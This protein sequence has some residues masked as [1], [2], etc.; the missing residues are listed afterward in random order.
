MQLG[1]TGVADIARTIASECQR[2]RKQ[3]GP[4]ARVALHSFSNGGTFMQLAL[5]AENGMHFDGVV[6]DSAPSLYTRFLPAGAPLV[7]AS[8][9]KPKGQM[10]LD[11]ARHGPYAA[12]AILATP[13]V[14]MPPPLGLFKRLFT[15]DSNPPRPELF[16]YS[17]KDTL[18]PA[19][20]VESFICLRRS[21]GCDPVHVLGPLAAS[22]HCAHGRVYPAEYA[23]A[24]KRFTEVLVGEQSPMTDAH[25]GDQAQ[26]TTI[27]SHL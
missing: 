12:A 9:G 5:L 13:F 18:I 23:E 16:V 14:D 17:A 7:L 1:W 3:Q 2:H 22:P 20:H 15:P 21:H 4:S 24:V 26:Q 19:H 6:Y 11:L 10:L 25:D 8:T 27:A